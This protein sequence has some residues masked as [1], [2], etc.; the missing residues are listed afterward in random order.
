M[1]FSELTEV[2]EKFENK[3]LSKDSDFI[4]YF[5]RQRSTTWM[6]WYFTL[7]VFDFFFCSLNYKGDEGKK[8]EE[9]LLLLLHHYIYKAGFQYLLLDSDTRK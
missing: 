5:A 7:D 1:Y 3:Y 6:I 2:G 4:F 8:A 9:M